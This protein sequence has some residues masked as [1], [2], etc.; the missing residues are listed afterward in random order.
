MEKRWLWSELG[1][2]PSMSR[3]ILHFKAKNKQ[4]PSNKRVGNRNVAE[5]RNNS[6]RGTATTAV[7]ATTVRGG[8]HG[9]WWP[10]VPPAFFFARTMR[11]AFCFDPR[12]ACLG[13]FALGFLACFL[14]L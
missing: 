8:H 11:F 5:N 3:Y 2:F 1:F 7:A 12:V 14:P 6:G 4:Q 13:L 9:P 10:L